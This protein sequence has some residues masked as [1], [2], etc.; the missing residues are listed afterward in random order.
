MAPGSIS[1]T[2]RDNVVEIGN[3]SAVTLHCAPPPAILRLSDRTHLTMQKRPRAF[4]FQIVTAKD[5]FRQ[6]NGHAQVASERISAPPRWVRDV[7]YQGPLQHSAEV[8]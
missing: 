6:Q 1:S 4:P 5:R 7:D 3:S 8:A 2:A